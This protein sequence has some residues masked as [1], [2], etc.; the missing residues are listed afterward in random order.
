MQSQLCIT[1]YLDTI[2]CS[3]ST[4]ALRAA[5]LQPEACCHAALLQSLFS[6]SLTAAAELKGRLVLLWESMLPAC[7]RQGF[8]SNQGCHSWKSEP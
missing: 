2:A 3:S 5:V 8:G 4:D 7:T 1:G 6:G